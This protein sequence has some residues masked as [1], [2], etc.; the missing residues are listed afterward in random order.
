V[1]PQALLAHTPL[2]GHELPTV[3]AYHT[4]FIVAGALALGAAVVPLLLRVRKGSAA[5]AVSEGAATTEAEAE[6]TLEPVAVLREP[7][8]V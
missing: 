5:P 6:A 8:L 1:I 4:A 3:T 2:A 7:E